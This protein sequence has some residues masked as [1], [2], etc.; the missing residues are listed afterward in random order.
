M[1]SPAG[2]FLWKRAQGAA[3]A[4]DTGDSGA[5]DTSRVGKACLD[6]NVATITG[7]TTPSI[8]FFVDRQG[9]DG[10]WYP[11]AQT[12]VLTATGQVSI[13]ICDSVA[14]GSDAQHM[15]FA[16]VAR[17]RWVFAGAVKATSIAF[18]GSL[19]GRE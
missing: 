17:V 8:Q 19:Y 10:L 6:V 13:E 1:G 15:I 11:V 16:D 12:A 18:S 7:G 4:T 3:A 2:N 9:G 5:F 14:D